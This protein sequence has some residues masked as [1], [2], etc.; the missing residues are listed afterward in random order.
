MPAKAGIQMRHRLKK[1]A[2]LFFAKKEAKKLPFTG[3]CGT[4]RTKSP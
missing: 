3:G 4:R 1:K 2:L